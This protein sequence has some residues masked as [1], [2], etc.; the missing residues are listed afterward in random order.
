MSKRIGIISIAE[1]SLTVQDSHRDGHRDGHKTIAIYPSLLDICSTVE[2]EFLSILNK[3]GM[4]HGEVLD[5]PERAPQYIAKEFRRSDMQFVSLDCYDYKSVGYI[6]NIVNIL[7][8]IETKHNIEC[9]LYVNK[10]SIVNSNLRT[11]E[12]NYIISDKIE[13]EL[14]DIWLAVLKNY[15]STGHINMLR[16]RANGD[17]HADKYRV[18]MFNGVILVKP[19]YPERIKFSK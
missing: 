8:N 5:E 14:F 6:V 4:M 16:T 11:F 2:D 19:L 12:G 18:E 15:I 7:Y 13:E 10:H 17:N 9:S 1:M 3:H